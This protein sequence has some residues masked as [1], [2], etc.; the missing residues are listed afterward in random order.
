M[1]VK[2]AQDL[3]ALMPLAK[4]I[5]NSFKLQLRYIGCLLC[6]QAAGLALI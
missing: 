5:Q 4:F 2:E 6:Y 1:A 3:L